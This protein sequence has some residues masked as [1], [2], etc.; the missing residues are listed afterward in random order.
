MTASALVMVT[1]GAFAIADV[2]PGGYHL[3]IFHE[4]SAE[5]ELPKLQRK[6][7]VNSGSLELPVLVLSESG[8]IQS[9]HKNKYGK[10]Y[11]PVIEDTTVYPGA[12]K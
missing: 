5:K 11:P 2:P 10:D 8:Y 1:A 12:K 9:P 7:V 6:I 4:R 3:Q